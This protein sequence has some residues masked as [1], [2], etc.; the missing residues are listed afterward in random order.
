MLRKAH[1]ARWVAQP[2]ARTSR[3]APQPPTQ[4]SQK[5]NASLGPRNRFAAYAQSVSY[6]I[7]VVEPGRNQRDL[8]NAFVVEASRPQSVMIRRRAAS[9]VF[10]QLGHVIE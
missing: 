8:Q 10:G 6:F 1:R 2:L 5:A 7:D 3:E 4:E 9:R